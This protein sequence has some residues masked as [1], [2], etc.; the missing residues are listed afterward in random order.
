MSKSINY[1]KGLIKKFNDN[2]DYHIGDELSWALDDL[3]LKEKEIKFLRAMVI[4]AR[5]IYFE[6]LEN[7]SLW[8]KINANNPIVKDWLKKTKNIEVK[9][10]D[11]E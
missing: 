2:G 10:E 1:M 3:E 8:V 6:G 4:D 9:N 11:N 5:N 7:G